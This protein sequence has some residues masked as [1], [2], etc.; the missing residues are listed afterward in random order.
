MNSLLKKTLI[1]ILIIF[2]ILG[3]LFVFLI[4]YSF[5]NNA[6]YINCGTEKYAIYREFEGVY[7]MYNTK[8][9]RFENNPDIVGSKIEKSLTTMLRVN[10]TGN[11]DDSE[12]EN[13]NFFIPIDDKI[14]E[15][16]KTNLKECYPKA[17]IVEYK[18]N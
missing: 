5:S 8:N 15:F 2:T 6:T 17:L 18:V 14:T 4:I 3:L 16:D 10:K 9:K 13:N 11:L 7:F 1:T 12:Y